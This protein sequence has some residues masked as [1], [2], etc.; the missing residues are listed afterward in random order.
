MNRALKR[1]SIAVLVMFV[2]LLVNINYLQGFETSS[3]ADDPGNQRAVDAQY[4]YQRGEI[5]TADGTVIARSKASP[6]GDSIP[7]QRYY[8]VP[9]VYAPVTGYDT[10]YSQTGIE[11]AENST[12]NGNS[13]S[14]DV[15]NF[16]DLITGKKQQGATV[17]V[18]VNS[19]AQEA[20]YSGLKNVLQGTGRI[21][22][23]VALDP[24]TGA[25]LAMASYP[26]YDPNLLAVQD[27]NTLNTNDKKLQ[28]QTG[29]P[30]RNHAINDTFPPG[31]TFKIVTSSAYFNANPGNSEQTPVYS[32]STLKLPQTTLQLINNDNEV[33][34]NGS[35]Q[36]PLITAFAQSCDTTFGKIGLDVGGS[37]LNTAAQAYGFNNQNLNI[38]MPVSASQY[39]I[40]PQGSPLV[41]YSAIGQYSDTATPLQEAMLSAAVANG[42]RLMTPYLVKSVTA[43][44]LSTIATTQPTMLGQAVPANAATS[45]GKMMEAVV[46]ESDGT[47]YDF[48]QSV[49]GVNI[50]GKTGTAQ[51]GVSNGKTS[52]AVFT[53]FAP[54]GNPKIA[55]G[56]IIQGGGYGA[57]AAAP[58]AV[59]VIK[60]YL[61]TLG[62]G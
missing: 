57:T 45:I 51:N 39:S 25:I 50:A 18:T 55:V 14:L 56:V 62:I 10:L 23:V 58:I 12:L 35:G 29:N 46:Q 24:S 48:N 3:L 20:A 28:A 36:V 59:Q 7:W 21:G 42:G 17:T 49:E 2:L 47:G 15:H 22:G 52:D 19:A 38:P 43:S 31:S 6:K 33:C 40:A 53:C 8:P 32:P 30:L 54:Y 26:S 13:S 9:D 61:K 1:L 16:I 11:A 5:V 34:G 41:A 4:Q 60:A 44:D 27:G 37:A